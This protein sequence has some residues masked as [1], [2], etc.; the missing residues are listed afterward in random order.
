MLVSAESND[1]P[2]ERNPGTALG[3][4]MAAAARAG[5]DKLT[6]VVP[7]H[8]APFGLWVEQ[9]VAESLGKDGVGI[10][11][12]VGERLNE[13]KQYSADRFFVCLQREDE[14]D[15]SVERFA[16]D[17]QRAGLPIALLSLP[18]L[19]GLGGEFV[20]WEIATAIAGA[21]LRVN[22]FD[23]PNVQQAKDATA[24]LLRHYREERELLLPHPDGRLSDGTVLSLTDKARERLGPSPETILRAVD[25]GDYVGVLAFLDETEALA[26]AFDELRAGIFSRTGAATTLGFGPRYLHSTGQLH[27]G[28][29]DTGVFLLLTAEHVRDAAVPG[30]PFTFGTLQF[31]Q[32]LGD[33]DAL[34][35]TGRRA[36]HV[37]LRSADPAVVVALSERLLSHAADRR[38]SARD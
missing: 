12:V 24:R 3:L 33:F 30:E 13:P 2:A 7:R 36:V 14:S 16:R 23:E 6:L 37:H 29:P 4:L 17:A 22:P 11:P 5:R 31:A 25:A 28:G 21:I 34:Q 27:K 18:Y 26:A 1:G 20:R 19:E 15:P 32:A 35:A 38:T 8:L 9:L 10:V